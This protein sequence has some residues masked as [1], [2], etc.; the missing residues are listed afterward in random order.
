MAQ[1]GQVLLQENEDR[2]QFLAT[3][4]AGAGRIPIDRLVEFSAK[5][6]AHELGV[7]IEEDNQQFPVWQ[8]NL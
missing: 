4:A 2:I 1:H 6:I 3:C 7:V 5:E 8:W